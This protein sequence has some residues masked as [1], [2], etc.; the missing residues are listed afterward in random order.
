MGTLAAN[1]V[2]TVLLRQT[3]FP[4][5]H[6]R[7]GMTHYFRGRDVKQ[8]VNAAPRLPAFTAALI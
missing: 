8:E 6:R 3:V 5:R 7:V 1:Y 4:A 2:E